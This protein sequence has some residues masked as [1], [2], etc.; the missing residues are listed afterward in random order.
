MGIISVF[1]WLFKNKSVTTHGN[2]NGRTV[3]TE[4]PTTMYSRV[5]TW[6]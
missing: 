6:H 3:R 1:G 4:Q 2:M 5:G